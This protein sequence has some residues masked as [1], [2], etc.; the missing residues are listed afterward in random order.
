MKILI[1]DDSPESR[2]LFK[3]Y[4]NTAGLKNVICVPSAKEAFALLL[5][6]NP[7]SQT[8]IDLILMDIVMPEI[9]GIEATRD[10]LSKE[11]LKDVPVIMITAKTDEDI[12]EQAFK[13]GAMDYI[14]K[15]TSTT[16]FLA[17]VRSALSL[18][19]ERDERKKRELEIMQSAAALKEANRRLKEQALV[20]GLTGIANRRRFDEE[21]EQNFRIAKRN[22]SYLSLIMIDIDFFKPYNDYFGHLA[23]DDCLR[24][25]AN[26]LKKNVRRPADLVSRFGGEEFT[27]ILPE[28][29]A[30]GAYHVAEKLRKAVEEANI[31]HPTSSVKDR[32]T[33]SLGVSTFKGTMEKEVIKLIE[34]ADEAL[35]RAK[36]RCRNCTEAAK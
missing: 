33:I 12:L 31:L 32:V 20:D 3:N 25:L 8:D 21:L 5:T 15:E 17:R 27:V 9:G 24:K 19:K 7:S 1:V 18:K 35:Y 13:A 30:K 26:I 22:N 16:V 14:T 34:E 6:D 28:T 10:I 4:L 2:M 36:Q 29:P 11:H 23:G